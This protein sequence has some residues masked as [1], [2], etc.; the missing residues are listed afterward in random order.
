MTGRM[1]RGLAVGAVFFCLGALAAC[2]KPFEIDLEIGSSDP[3]AAAGEP[4]NSPAVSSAGEAV[5]P[6]PPASA[7]SGPEEGPARYADTLTELETWEVYRRCVALVSVRD[8]DRFDV[9]FEVLQGRIAGGTLSESGF[10]GREWNR[11]ATVVRLQELRAESFLERGDLDRAEEAALVAAKAANETPN[12]VVEEAAEDWLLKLMSRADYGDSDQPFAHMR[13][14]SMALA[15]AVAAERGDEDLARTYLA[16]ID[17]F[18]PALGSNGHAALWRRW[19]AIG[20]FVLG[21]YEDTYKTLS[22]GTDMGIGGTAYQ[23]MVAIDAVDPQAGLLL[24]DTPAGR[25]LDPRYV[26]ELEHAFMRL[27]SALET[28]RLDEAEAGLDALLNDDRLKHHPAIHARVL[29]DRGRVSAMNGA[30][31]GAVASF[32]VAI[33]VMEATRSARVTGAGKLG[34][35]DDAQALY[36]DM[37]ASQVAI[38]QAAAAFFYAERARSRALVDSL[39]GKSRFAAAPELERTLIARADSETRAATLVQR[40]APVLA[41]EAA[42]FADFRQTVRADA[43]SLAG[44]VFV[45]AAPT[46]DIQ[47][48]L[49]DDEALLA[50]F[51]HGDRLFG[52]A[53]TRDSASAVALDGEDLDVLVSGFLR[54]I[55]NPRRRAYVSWARRLYNGL[56]RPF[57][58]ALAGRRLVIVP[59]GA[60]SGLPFAALRD[61]EGY[62]IESHALRLL[63]SARHLTAPGAAPLRPNLGLLLLDPPEP[64][65][66]SPDSPGSPAET[67]AVGRSWP[68]AMLVVGRGAT[69]TLLKDAGTRASYLHVSAR[70]DS[71]PAALLAGDAENDG[72]LTLWELYDMALDVRLVNLSRCQTGPGDAALGGLSDGFMH[73]GARALAVSLWPVADDAAAGLLER[74]YENLRGGDGAEA[75]RAAQRAGDGGL[76]HPYYWAGFQWLG[77]ADV[78]GRPGEG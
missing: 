11:A 69:E 57:E 60:L 36:A 74:F 47:A 51:Q 1:R 48:R 63:P 21:D 19:K 64:G 3:E 38:G 45:D 73:A 78:A 71:G 34:G 37:V 72:R 65:Q 39:A 25:A 52:F 32:E 49:A 20:H 6:A 7:G 24:P 77:A 2:E 44:V 26:M 75:L 55:R 29:R 33:D 9:C 17:S 22:R 76:A 56:I 4:D 35:W 27:R 67:A 13:L 18:D 28:G 50:Y 53:L 5:A 62:L 66:P 15:L 61:D 58:E 68:E 10:A 8:H 59:H 42:A 23:A 41:D 16:E 12:Y 54:A 70:C 40:P 46:R 43:P 30:H 31:E 14:R